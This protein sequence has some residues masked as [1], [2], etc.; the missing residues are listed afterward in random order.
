MAQQTQEPASYGI[1]IQTGENKFM[2]AGYNLSVSTSSTNPKKEVWLKDAWEGNY[3]NG[4]WKPKALHNGDEAGFL[5]S[6]NPT[7][8]IRAYRTNPSEPAI[9]KF[10]VLIYER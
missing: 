6:D 1:F 4:I 7:Y 9:F 5:R 8:G 10:K 2:V 3:V